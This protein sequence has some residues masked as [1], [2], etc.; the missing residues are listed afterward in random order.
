MQRH[1]GILR[2]FWQTHAS[3]TRG[4]ALVV[5]MFLAGTA[6]IAMAWRSHMVDVRLHQQQQ[7]QAQ[8]AQQQEQQAQV[9]Q[10]PRQQQAGLV[11]APTLPAAAAVAAAAA[12]SAAESS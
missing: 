12:A 9:L 6:G 2:T 3:F 10:R 7:Q 4:D 1:A 5:A 8:Q 11:Q